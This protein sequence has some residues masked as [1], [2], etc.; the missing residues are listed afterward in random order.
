MAK[1]RRQVKLCNAAWQMWL[2]GQPM[3]AD[4]RHV[5]GGMIASF[6]ENFGCVV[7]ESKFNSDSEE[8]EWALYKVLLSTNRYSVLR[9]PHIGYGYD[10]RAN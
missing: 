6:D 9:T 4:K 5:C 2:G 8:T 1:S 7:S 3:P 10:I